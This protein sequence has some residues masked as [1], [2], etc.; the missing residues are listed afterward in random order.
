MSVLHKLRHVLSLS[1]ALGQRPRKAKAS[2]GDTPLE[3]VEFRL[4][5]AGE[6][7]RVDELSYD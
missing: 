3:E 4:R 2:V 1:R 7:T 6:R 5:V